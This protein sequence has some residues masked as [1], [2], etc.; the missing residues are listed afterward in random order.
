MSGKGKAPS[1]PAASAGADQGYDHAGPGGEV[2]GD[3]GASY[4]NRYWA[5]PTAAAY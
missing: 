4:G 2:A 3:I 1:G 5:A